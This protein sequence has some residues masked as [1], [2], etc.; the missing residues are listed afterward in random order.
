MDVHVVVQQR[1]PRILILA[2]VVAIDHA[3]R[4][5]LEGPC[6][7][8]CTDSSVSAQFHAQQLIPNKLLQ[9]DGKDNAVHGQKLR[10]HGETHNA[11]DVN[12]ALVD[13]FRAPPEEIMVGGALGVALLGSIIVFLSLFYML[14]HPDAQ[15][16][17]YSHKIVFAITSV[18]C[19]LVVEQMEGK[20]LKRGILPVTTPGVVLELCELLLFIFHFASLTFAVY[21]Y[22]S[23]HE[24][25]F[26][27]VG[28]LSHVLA[29]IAID[30]FYDWLRYTG[31]SF[32][33]QEGYGL[34][35]LYGIAPIIGI[36]L[37]AVCNK[38]TSLL[39]GRVIQP[40]LNS[41]RTQVALGEGSDGQ[42]SH[43]DE[44][45][46]GAISG[47]DHCDAAA[48]A[49]AKEAATGEREACA[50]FVGF[51]L[52]SLCVL[53]VSGQ[54]PPIHCNDHKGE[55]N[56]SWG[57]IGGLFLLILLQS[58]VVG[59]LPVFFGTDSRLVTHTQMLLS[60]SV[61]WCLDS[62]V[63]WLLLGNSVKGEIPVPGGS[64]GI[65]ITCAFLVSPI[66][67]FTV[68]ALDALADRG[69][70]S[71]HASDVFIMVAGLSI[72]ILWQEAFAESMNFAVR[73]NDWGNRHSLL[74]NLVGG[75]TLISFIVPAWRFWIV[76][77]ASA[78]VPKRIEAFPDQKPMPETLQNDDTEEAAAE[79]W[80]ASLEHTIS[81][82]WPM[83]DQ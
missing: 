46:Y 5:P 7:G 29:F 72:G 47:H 69:I 28:V 21:V 82:L 48:P 11:G 27:A 75:C 51:L 64:A 1:I 8:N 62:A 66:V 63:R 9:V 13:D 79:T 10:A 25:M 41:A 35:F 49:W 65:E 37:F 44:N 38:L 20:M 42:H 83:S 73:C 57:E 60:Y 26:G 12:P 24:L 58:L 31:E 74:C 78:P 39:R 19:A 36:E 14:R 15:V 77:V 18:L 2:C 17:S 16:A 52:R 80:M 53:I 40:S 43:H 67:V 45:H 68:I 3:S 23:S 50:I 55:C 76:P 22:R 71:D 30:L 81:G 61:G 4:R 56:H 32:V 6:L 34:Y 54:A 33:S 59:V 70:L